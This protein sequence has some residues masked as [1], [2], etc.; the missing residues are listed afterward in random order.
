MP[1]IYSEEKTSQKLPKVAGNR[2]KNIY[3]IKLGKQKTNR[4]VTNWKPG[5]H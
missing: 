2:L 5:V 3:Q 1:R 4:L